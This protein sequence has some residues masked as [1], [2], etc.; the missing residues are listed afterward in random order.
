MAAG[1]RVFLRSDILS[2]LKSYTGNNQI[3]IDYRSYLESISEEVENYLIQPL[4]NWNRYSWMGF[5]QQL[6][7]ELKDGEWGYVP[8]PSGGFMGLWWHFH[9]NQECKQYLQIEET[10]L[11]FKIMVSDKDKRR[12]YRNTW[13]NRIIENSAGLE[14]QIS[15]PERFGLGQYMTV[16]ILDEEYRAV[17]N[18]GLIDINATLVRLRQVEKTLTKA[19]RITKN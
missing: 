13:H 7:V 9:E 1:Y 8:N 16:C 14:L 19:I 18:N 11:C 10:N 4:E 15:K 3:L 17:D 12:E 2:L 5:Y 6:Q